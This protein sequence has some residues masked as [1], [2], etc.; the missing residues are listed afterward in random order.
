MDELIEL[1]EK[2]PCCG[3]GGYS[4]PPKDHDDA[5]LACEWCTK[6][7]DGTPHDCVSAKMIR[8]KRKP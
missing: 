8:E 1:I 3:W 4:D 6:A 5:V 7:I 2:C